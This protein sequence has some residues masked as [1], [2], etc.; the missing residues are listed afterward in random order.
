MKT[1]VVL[2]LAVATFI[3]AAALPAILRPLL[4]RAKI[5]DVPNERSSHNAPAIRGM[6]LAPAMSLLGALLTILWIEN[7]ANQ[8]TVTGMFVTVFGATMVGWLE[9]WQGVPSL[10]RAVAQAVVGAIGTAIILGGIGGPFW[11]L[12]F[13]TLIVVAYINVA[14]FMDGIN[15]ISGGHGICVGFHYAT[16]G[17]ILDLGLLMLMGMLLGLVFGAFVPWNIIHGKM[18]LGDVGSYLLGSSIA[19][20]AIMA[21]LNGVHPIAVLGPVSV[22]LADTGWT[23]VRRILRGEKWTDAHRSHTYQ[24]LIDAGQS[25]NRVTVLVSAIGITTGLM[26]MISVWAP[27]AGWTISLPLMLLMCAGYIRLPHMLETTRL[28]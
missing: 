28:L 19:A 26:G 2:V 9:D 4:E 18:F 22:Y 21:L 10:L 7:G 27:V 12:L 24:K 3:T 5:M 20:L 8:I 1:D 17:F 15:G 14:N 23:L 11:W 6:G 25:H 13:G 16:L